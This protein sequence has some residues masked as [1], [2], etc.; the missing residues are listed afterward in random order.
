MKET[1]TVIP[2]IPDRVELDGRYH[3]NCRVTI[4]IDDRQDFYL[5][6]VF[7]D[8]NLQELRIVTQLGKLS[9]PVPIWSPVLSDER[10]NISEIT[11]MR[12]WAAST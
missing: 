10:Y 9:R 3:F 12:T 2:D 8:L 5:R 11:I 1:I 7:N 4:G 6:M